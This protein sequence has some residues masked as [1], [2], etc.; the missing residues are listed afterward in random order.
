MLPKSIFEMLKNL[1]G[2][3]TKRF[4]ECSKM[5]LLLEIGK[6]S[7]ENPVVARE[8]SCHNTKMTEVSCR[9]NKDRRLM[10]RHK[11]KHVT[12]HPQMDF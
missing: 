7:R 12:A 11:K 2:I 3:A 9:H 5:N 8:N 4:K 1:L 6:F 10:P